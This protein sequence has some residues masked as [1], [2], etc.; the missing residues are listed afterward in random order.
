MILSSLHVLEL[1][2]VSLEPNNPSIHFYSGQTASRHQNCSTLTRA[3]TLRFL[4]EPT[5]VT[6]GHSTHSEGPT[7]SQ[8]HLAVRHLQRAKTSRAP[9]P[10]LQ[11][12]LIFPMHLFSAVS[13]QSTLS[14]SVLLSLSVIVASYTVSFQQA[15][16]ISIPINQPVPL[17]TFSQPTNQ[18]LSVI[19][20][21]KPAFLCLFSLATSS[22]RTHQRYTC[23]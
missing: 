3:H 15:P 9:R 19:E 23:F 20:K 17:L 8:S 6:P 7:T 18:P 22:L 13:D 2:A 16:S 10:A 11:Y 21:T 1:E 12:E 14:Q 4:S 5:L